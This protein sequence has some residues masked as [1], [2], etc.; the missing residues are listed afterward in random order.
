MQQGQG[1]MMGMGADVNLRTVG[2]EQ[3]VRAI[4][5]CGDTFRVTTADG[6][7]RAFWERNLRLMIDSSDKGP[8]KD[9]P[10]LVGAG[11]M[12]D[13]ADAIFTAPEEISGFIKHDCAKDATP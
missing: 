11:M 1:G 3:R 4:T 7:T 12:G 6:H 5:Y 9:A 10:A 13:R 8:E 2:P